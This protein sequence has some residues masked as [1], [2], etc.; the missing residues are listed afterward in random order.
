MRKA[1]SALTVYD[2]KDADGRVVAFQVENLGLGRRS[3]CKLV[4]QIRGCR[5]VK[6]PGFFSWFREDDF[7]QFKM[8]DITFAVAE[9]FGD[10]SLYW[11]D[12]QPLRW[13]PRLR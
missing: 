6:G 12:P 10:N 4:A 1:E 2:I 13:V 9:P 11:V 5:I 7:C 8:G 3:A